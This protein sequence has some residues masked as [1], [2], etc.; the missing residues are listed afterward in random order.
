MHTYGEQL[1]LSPVTT[2]HGSTSV[3]QSE[4]T[5]IKSIVMP[6][7]FVCSKLCPG[8]SAARCM[9]RSCVAYTG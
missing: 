6:G 7:P 9:C 1:S 2:M 8:I 3:C 5:N 4:P